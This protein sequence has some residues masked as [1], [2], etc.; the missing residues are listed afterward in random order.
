MVPSRA[1]SRDTGGEMHTGGPNSLQIPLVPTN[2]EVRDSRS[3]LSLTIKNL[4]AHAARAPTFAFSWTNF[5]VAS[6]EPSPATFFGFGTH[7]SPPVT[8]PLGT[9]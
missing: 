8:C 6:S 7:K 5:F 4:D 3:R 2:S 1:F 9:T